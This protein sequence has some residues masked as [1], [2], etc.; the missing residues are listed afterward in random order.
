MQQEYLSYF[1]GSAASALTAI[2]NLATHILENGPYDAIMGFSMGG[3]MAAT[4]LL[5]PQNPE[6]D[7]PSWLAARKL[8][9]GA[10]F[11]CS[12][13]P[14]DTMELRHGRMGWVKAEDVGPAGKLH[15]I[16]VPTVHAWSPRD[17]CNCAE[18]RLLVSMCI[19]TQRTEVLHDAGHGIPS[20]ISEVTSMSDVIQG[21]MNKIEQ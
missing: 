20:G 11:I 16:G 9:R 17:L 15:P 2:D 8:I 4:L 6:A 19:E 10:V 5:Q 13:L 7:N 1:D 21:M 14:V 3:A 18:S 12:T